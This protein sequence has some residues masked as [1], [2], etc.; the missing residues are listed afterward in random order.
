VTT[1]GWTRHWN[2]S[3]PRLALDAIIVEASGIAD[4]AILARMIRFSGA[5]HVRPGGVIDVIDAVHHFGTVDLGGTVPLR[6]AAATLIVINKL[7]QVEPA[8]RTPTVRRIEAR[9]R[10]RNPRACIVPVSRGRVDPALVFDIAN[11]QDDPDQLPLRALLLQ[12]HSEDQ[13]DGAGA[14]G[15]VARTAHRRPHHEHDGADDPHAAAGHRHVAA[16]TVSRSGSVD[17]G[18]VIDLLED[19][20]PGVY[21]I[22]GTITVRARTYLVDLVGHSVHVRTGPPPGDVANRV[23]AI[24]PDLDTVAVRHRLAHALEPAGTI[25]AAGLRRL[26]RHRRLSL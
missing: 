5:E 11:D 22:K 18:R 1:T 8:A 14:D 6:Y 19:P 24:G 12:D 21:R 23:V 16:V 20:P 10:E 2:D 17:P 25:D 13:H 9:V 3:Q 15:G 7:D 26:H 4:P